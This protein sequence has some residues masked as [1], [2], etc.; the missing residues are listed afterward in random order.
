M[1]KVGSD[2]QIFESVVKSLVQKW[3]KEGFEQEDILNFLQFE[4]DTAVEKVSGK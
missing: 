1:I 2:I 4:L 3:K